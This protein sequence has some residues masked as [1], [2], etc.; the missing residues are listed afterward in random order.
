MTIGANCEMIA[1]RLGYMTPER[2]SRWPLLVLIS[3]FF[4][5]GLLAQ[6]PQSNSYHDTNL[7]VLKAQ[8]LQHPSSYAFLKE[9]SDGIGPRLTGSV[10]DS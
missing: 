2:K 5:F 7:N 8:A 10:E 4:S 6:A 1:R 9:L 3:S